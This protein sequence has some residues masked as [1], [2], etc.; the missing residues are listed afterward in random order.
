[1]NTREVDE[2]TCEAA[3]HDFPVWRCYAVSMAEVKCPEVNG[4]WNTSNL[5]EWIDTWLRAA[6]N[7]VALADGLKKQKRYWIGPI[8]FPLEKLARCCGP[9]EEMEFRE[10][11]E[12]WNQRIDS[13]V[14]QIQSGVGLAPFIAT[15]GNGTYSIRDGNHRYGAYKKLGLKTYWTIIWCD[16]KDDFEKV[17]SS[18]N[19]DH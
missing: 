3:E 12:R 10:P 8:R 5:E 18:L 2:R 11:V 19:Y 13:L 1:M 15:Y 6:G 17:K 7:N 16:T 9:E 14:E 4:D